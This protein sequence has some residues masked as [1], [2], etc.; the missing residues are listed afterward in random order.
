MPEAE[1]VFILFVKRERFKAFVGDTECPYGC[2]IG[3]GCEFFGTIL[4]AD[5]MDEVQNHMTLIHEM[6]HMAVDSKFK[7]SMFHGKHWKAEM[8][9]LAAEGAFDYDW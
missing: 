8:R 6:A 5:D 9:R 1:N 4:L 3:D 2:Y 7:R